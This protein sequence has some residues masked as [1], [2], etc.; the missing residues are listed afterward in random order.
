M[1]Q[2]GGWVG[3]GTAAAVLALALPSA[4]ACVALDDFP[5]D[6]LEKVYALGRARDAARTRPLRAARARGL[7]GLVRHAQHEHGLWRA[8]AARAA[9]FR[10]RTAPVIAHYAPWWRAQARPRS[11][12]RSAC[13]S[14]SRPSSCCC[15]GR[16]CARAGREWREW[17][18]AAELVAREARTGSPAGQRIRELQRRGERLLTALVAQQL[19]E[20]VE[21]A[22][23]R[24]VCLAG[25]PRSLA[26]LRRA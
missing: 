11:R 16:T 2:N 18:Y 13:S 25:S 8:V 7:L 21:R 22:G 3:A 26:N 19:R 10:E 20:A 17:R 9:Q 6:L 24:R 1:R 12:S 4:G 23:S 15:S 5:R 14:G